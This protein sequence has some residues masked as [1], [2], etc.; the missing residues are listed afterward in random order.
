[1]ADVDPALG[2][3][4]DQ[5]AAAVAQV[6][7]DHGGLLALEGVLGVDVHSGDAQVAP[8]LLHL[9][10]DVGRPHE[11]DV[12]PRLA[13]DRRLVLPVAGAA[14]LVAGRL[15]EVDDPLVKVPLRGNRQADGVNRACS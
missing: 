8:P 5:P 14:D 13:G 11:D 1:M 10:H 2:N 3:G 12:K 15:Q 9:D 7:N 4:D 6:G